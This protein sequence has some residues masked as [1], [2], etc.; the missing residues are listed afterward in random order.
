MSRQCRFDVCL[1]LGACAS[2]LG[3][4]CDPKTGRYA[5]AEAVNVD[6][7]AGRL[8]RRPGCVRL[9]EGGFRSLFSHGPDLYGVRD[10]AIYR[11]P[12]QGEPRCLKSGLTPGAEVAF[13]GLGDTVY[14]ANGFESGRIRDGAAGAW[15]GEP[16][17]GP[18]R[19]GRYVSP[20]PG[21]LLAAHAGRIWLADAAVVRFTLGA[22][23]HDWVDALA[24]F[25]PPV[26]GRV[27]LLRAVSGGLFIGDAA[28][29]TFAA[30]NDPNTMTFARVCP[31]PPIPGSDATLAAG[32]R[33][34][35]GGP[36]GLDAAGDAAVWAASDG[37]YLGRPTGAVVRL[38]AANIPDG[39]A[40]ATVSHS[41]YLL[42][43][44]R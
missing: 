31:A 19:L 35:S 42:C 43:L 9:G 27:R 8:V 1:G 3:L 30:G 24:G 39:R 40:R 36:D 34:A 44:T 14:F 2:P 15:G 41:R 11:I 29:V 10:D 20:P 4:D 37:I 16:Y 18:D 32:G 17:P 23:L 28:G 33:D 13:L 26:T 22:G 21:H 25:L 38:A 6:V 7:V 5:L 12:D